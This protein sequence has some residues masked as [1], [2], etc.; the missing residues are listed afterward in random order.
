MVLGREAAR[1]IWTL[2]QDCYINENYTSEVSIRDMFGAVR[3][4][5]AS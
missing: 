4:G 5:N 2:K 3:Y 1:V